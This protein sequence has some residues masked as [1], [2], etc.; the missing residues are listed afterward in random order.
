V[1]C[2]STFGE[3]VRV[4]GQDHLA[5]IGLTPARFEVLASRLRAFGEHL[6]VPG[7][8]ERIM[9]DADD[10]VFLA[11]AVTAGVDYLVSGDK[12]FLGDP[13]VREHLAA[14]G[15]ALVTVREFVETLERLP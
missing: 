1:F 8:I 11:L 7:E 10:D 5:K 4:A 15:V 9:R 14:H 12:D 13:A 3:L 2:S 6:P